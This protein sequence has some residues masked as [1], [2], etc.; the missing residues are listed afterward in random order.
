M[1]ILVLTQFSELGGSSRIQVI[2]FLPFLEKAGINC[3]WKHFYSDKFYKIQNGI[4]PISRLRKKVNFFCHLFLVMLKKIFYVF[5]AG[6]YDLV[7]IQRE[8]FPKTLYWLLR[9]INPRVIYEIED[10]IYEINP[11]WKRGFIHDFALLYQARLCLNMM[12]GAALV[13]AENEYLAEEAQKHNSRISLI[14]APINT[15]IF[16]PALKQD[17]L[18]KR[19]VTLGWMGSPSTTPLLKSLGP[20]FAELGKRFP[21]VQLKTVGAALDFLVSGI[22]LVKKEWRLEEEFSDLWSFDIGLMPLD[23]TPFNRGRLGYK[24][25]QYMSI[26]IP[27][28][29]Q[30]IGLNRAVIKNGENGFLVSTPEEWVE[31]LS[32]LIRDRG[33]GEK[34]GA[35][36][37]KM[38][39]EIF[40]LEKQSKVYI[41][42]IRKVGGL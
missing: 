5:S 21:H 34:L 42:V 23:D 13:I 24:M 33:L 35:G 8:V 37:R 3:A 7:L 14:T 38:A 25:I 30:D 22:T 15:E 32:L 39:E 1:K 40:S 18:E 11:F 4:V 2:Q 20:V 19:A 31:K 17:V 41:E 16:K 28:V 26:G 36:G 10:T 27:V 29:A 12:K 9:K 6:N